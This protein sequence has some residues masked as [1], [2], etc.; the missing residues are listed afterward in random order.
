MLVDAAD[1]GLAGDQFPGV[2]VVG[3]IR[4]CQGDARP[5]VAVITGHYF[6]DG[7]RHRMAGAGADLFF[8]RPELRSPAALWDVVLHP[9]HY[10][11]GVPGLLDPVAAEG[12]GIT[13]SSHLEGL[14][15]YVQCHGIEDAL[16]PANPRRETREGAVGC[17]TAGRSP[18]RPGSR[19]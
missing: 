9:E 15:T 14:V 12:I 13:E 7:L 17:A 4:A 16:D 2:A 8:L 10:R 1:E 3:R 18:E 6:N 11:R 5:L 19:R